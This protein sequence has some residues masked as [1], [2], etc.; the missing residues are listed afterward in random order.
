MSL[1]TI[2]VVFVVVGVALWLI[3]QFIPM[4]PRI[5]TALSVVVVVVL[6]VWVL[7]GLLETGAFPDI[8]IGG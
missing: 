4:D 6:L 8:R 7:T 5:K 1:W 2:I 3:N